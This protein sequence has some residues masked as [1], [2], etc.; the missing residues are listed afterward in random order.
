MTTTTP[1][2]GERELCAG[3]ASA[4]D[5]GRR[6][7]S[8]AERRLALSIA[9]A[10]LSSDEE[11]EPSASAEMCA[12]SVDG[13]DRMLGAC[14]APIREGLCALLR[15]VEWLPPLVVRRVR[16]ASHLSLTD[17]IHY[18]E[19]LETS[20][21]PFLPMVLVAVKVPLTLNAY[22]EG[23]ALRATGYDRPSTSARRGPVPIARRLP[24]E[25]HG[26]TGAASGPGRAP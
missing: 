23:E 6:G 26:V 21:L 8:A 4:P 15:L 3:V 19:A 24:V 11:G 22:E 1:E 9:E 7:L 20:R 14:S 17:R 10:L 25:P 16:R 18:L 12:R 5:W 2:V 13:L